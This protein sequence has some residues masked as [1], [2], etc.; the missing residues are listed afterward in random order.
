MNLKIKGWENVPEHR[1]Q[2]FYLDL[3]SVLNKYELFGVFE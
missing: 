2:K 1:K 3:E